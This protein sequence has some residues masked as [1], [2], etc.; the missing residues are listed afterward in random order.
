MS[1]LLLV[2]MNHNPSE[3]QKA[4]GNYAK[5]HIRFQGLDIALENKKG[6]TRH[7]IDKNGKQWSCVLPAHYGY[8]KRTEGADGDHVDVYIGPD[9]N[10]K[11]VF[12]VNQR[13]LGG[14]FDEHKALL[15]L[16]SERAARDCY[17]RAFSDGKGRERLGSMET[18]SMDAFKHWLKSGNT[19][20]PASGHNI[21]HKALGIIRQPVAAMSR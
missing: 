21:V 4:A 3:A 16:D 8:I 12:V 17:V 18:M 6:S 9:P 19:K 2:A 11:Q 10:S 1:L 7:G 14:G 5:E 15:G 20:A 13:H